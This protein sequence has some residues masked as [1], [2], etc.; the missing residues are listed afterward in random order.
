MIEKDML[1][2]ELLEKDERAA[3]IL[4][5]SGMHC[6]GCAAAGGETIEEA[7]LEHGLDPV[8]LVRKLNLYLNRQ[9]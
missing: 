6:I 8:L 3:A 9:V 7:A 1:I 4:A 2:S 5:Q